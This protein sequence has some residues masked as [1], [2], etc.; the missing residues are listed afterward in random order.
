MEK[1][2]KPQHPTIYDARNITEPDIKFIS[3]YTGHIPERRHRLGTNKFT[4]YREGLADY[5]FRRNVKEAWR[6]HHIHDYLTFDVKKTAKTEDVVLPKEQRFLKPYERN[7]LQLRKC[8]CFGS[9]D[10]HYLYKNFLEEEPMTDEELYKAP[11]FQKTNNL[12]SD[13]EPFM[14]REKKF[15]RKYYPG[16]VDIAPQPRLGPRPSRLKYK[17]LEDKTRECNPNYLLSW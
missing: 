17:K 14:S 3:N 13:K 6:Q 8:P 16:E 7:L 1:K 11:R 4:D 10:V 15:E 9:S 12:L 2:V 5:H